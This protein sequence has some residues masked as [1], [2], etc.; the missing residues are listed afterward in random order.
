MRELLF[1][2]INDLGDGQVYIAAIWLIVALAIGGVLLRDGLVWL[3]SLSDP[4][5]TSDG[6]DMPADDIGDL[7]HNQQPMRKAALTRSAFGR[8]RQTS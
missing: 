4:V 5:D 3:A 2:S 8:R 1:V 6:D 7:D